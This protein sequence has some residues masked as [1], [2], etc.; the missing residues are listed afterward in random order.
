MTPPPIPEESREL[1]EMA[2]AKAEA[3]IKNAKRCAS[4]GGK[5]ETEIRY[6]CDVQCGGPDMAYL[7]GMLDVLRPD[8]EAAIIEGIRA[9]LEAAKKACMAKVKIES[10]GFDHTD[11]SPVKLL[12]EIDEILEGI[13]GASK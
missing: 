11:R 3:A 13:N 8:F 6:T 7:S 9:G 10:D 5:A 12:G 1:L 4:C 2:R